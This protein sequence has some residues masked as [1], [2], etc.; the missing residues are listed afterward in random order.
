MLQLK[1]GIFSVLPG[2]LQSNKGLGNRGL[3]KVKGIGEM[4]VTGRVS[5]NGREMCGWEKGRQ[6]LQGNWKGVL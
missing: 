1:V 5:R 6:E 3:E 4:D 2:S